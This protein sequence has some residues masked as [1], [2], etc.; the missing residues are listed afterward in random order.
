M[1]S[2]DKESII[3]ALLHCQLFSKLTH[4][5][6]HIVADL[7][8]PIS[9]NAGAILFKQGDTGDC[10][11]IVVKGH[12]VSI[13]KDED[14][15]ERQIYEFGTG[16]FFGE[17]SIIDHE[18]RS[19]TCEA[20]EDSLLLALDAIDFYR[21]IWE[22]ADIGVKILTAMTSTMTEWLNEASSFLNDI[23]RWG[24]TARKR[25]I[26]DDMSGL[27]N[28]RFLEESMIGWFS[29]LSDSHASTNMKC[30]LLMLDIDRFHI[31][32]ETFGQ[33]A[34]D[35]VIATAGAAFSRCVTDGV[36]A[37]RLSGDE[38]AFF[39]PGADLQDAVALAEHIR[40][41]SELLYLEFRKGKESNPKNI[42][43]KVSLGVAVFPDHAKTKDELYQKAD[44]ALFIAKETG[45][46]KVVVFS[47]TT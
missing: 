42:Q 26:T 46:N 2:M 5:E 18:K 25:A 41:E 23:V 7:V 33:E 11:Y 39:M 3:K 6:L 38:F 37:S 47:H 35:A 19:A 24:E 8:R 10:M 31:V 44:K 17:M 13:T 21:I 32:N 36:I 4:D 20:S 28:R 40:K 22:C 27:F 9:V 12:V 30:A 14:G 29:K 1:N 45:R 43:I 16:A 15:I 34:G